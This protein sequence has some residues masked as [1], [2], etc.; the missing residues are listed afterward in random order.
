M[1]KNQSHDL[2]S[3]IQ[4]FSKHMQAHIQTHAKHIN[5]MFG[6]WMDCG[7]AG[8]EGTES[9]SIITQIVTLGQQMSLRSDVSVQSPAGSYRVII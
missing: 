8:G 1:P 2:W 4:C 3:L 9:D 6:T 7:T 5:V